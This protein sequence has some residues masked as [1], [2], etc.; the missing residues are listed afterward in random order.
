MQICAKIRR[1]HTEVRLPL[2]RHPV[3]FPRKKYSCVPEKG[4]DSGTAQANVDHLRN[5]TS[6][7]ERRALIHAGKIEDEGAYYLRELGLAGPS[8]T[9]YFEGG[10]RSL[11]QFQ[12]RH[13]SPV[14][15][16]IFYVEKEQDGVAVEVALQY[17]DDVS[18]R[19][20]AFANNI[21]NAEGGMHITGFKTALTRTLNA[22]LKNGSGKEQDSFTGDDVL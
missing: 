5:R 2:Q 17:V 4:D 1:L 6:L 20:S 8:M 21:Y 14:H 9:F 12:N 7:T 13:L 22:Q 3:L 15:K 16:N 19:I 10:L 11:V 18:S